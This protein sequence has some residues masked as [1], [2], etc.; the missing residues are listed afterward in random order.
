MFQVELECSGDVLFK[1]GVA[2]GE[3]GIGNVMLKCILV[4][5]VLTLELAW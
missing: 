5:I 2:T 1:D 4:Q 3:C